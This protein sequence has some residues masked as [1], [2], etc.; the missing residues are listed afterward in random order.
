MANPWR[1]DWT[2]PAPPPEPK[3]IRQ[4]ERLTRT[5]R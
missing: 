2:Q 4:R 1:E 3:R 5:N